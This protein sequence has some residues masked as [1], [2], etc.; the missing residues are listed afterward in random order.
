MKMVASVGAVQGPWRR[1]LNRALGDNDMEEELLGFTQLIIY[2]L[3]LGT[4]ILS[5][6]ES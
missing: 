6:S 1:R 3:V 5:G 2:S 4:S